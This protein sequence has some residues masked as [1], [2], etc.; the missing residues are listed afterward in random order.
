MSKNKHEIYPDTRLYIV[1][2]IISQNRNVMYFVLFNLHGF[3]FSFFL[4]FFFFQSM[5]PNEQL[6]PFFGI[7]WSTIWAVKLLTIMNMH[8]QTCVKN[9]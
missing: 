8:I 4:F 9:N 7:V 3:F 1:P 6:N 2:I 5:H